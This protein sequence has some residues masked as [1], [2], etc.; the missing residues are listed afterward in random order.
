MEPRGDPPGPHPGRGRGGGAGAGTGAGIEAAI[1][2]PIL[3]LP[4][5]PPPR[6]PAAPR[7]PP[8]FVRRGPE[9]RARGLRTTNPGSPG[10]GPGPPPPGGL[11]SHGRAR[12][13]HTPPPRPHRTPPAAAATAAP[14]PPPT[15]FQFF[16]PLGAGGAL[17]LPS[18]AFLPPPKDKRLSPELPLP[19]QLVCRWSKVSR[20]GHG[21]G[22]GGQQAWG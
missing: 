18:S 5:P 19:K 7:G 12:S 17:H 6:P 9:D 20:G 4:P 21:R 22:A 8:G 3:L 10:P 16:L 13:K 1:P 15:S 2:I 11:Q 14:P